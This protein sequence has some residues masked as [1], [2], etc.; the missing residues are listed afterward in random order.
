M[1]LLYWLLT[2]TFILK[3]SNIESEWMHTY[4][5]IPPGGAPA[6]YNGFVQPFLAWIRPSIA[7]GRRG[8]TPEMYSRRGFQRTQLASVTYLPQS[9]A[10]L[11][12][13]PSNKRP[14]RSVFAD[15]R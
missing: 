2:Q 7:L 11:A 12:R 14:D 15:A 4:R 5:D 6:P 9:K 1:R 8:S 10:P 3:I 13:N